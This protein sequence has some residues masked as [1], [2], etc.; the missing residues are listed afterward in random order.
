MVTD[1]KDDKSGGHTDREKDAE[2]AVLRSIILWTKPQKIITYTPSPT[3]GAVTIDV[4]DDVTG[5]EGIEDIRQ[6]DSTVNKGSPLHRGD[7][8]DKQTVHCASMS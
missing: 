6:I 8:G 3:V 1:Q 4:G 2:H 7:I 5:D